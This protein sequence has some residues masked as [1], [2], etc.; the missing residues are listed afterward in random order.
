MDTD[1]QTEI[2]IYT[3]THVLYINYLYRVWTVCFKLLVI[4]QL[5]RRFR[6]IEHASVS[7]VHS[8][9]YTAEGAHTVCISNKQKARRLPRCVYIPR[10]SSIITTP[11]GAA[12]I[13]AI[14]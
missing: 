14:Y 8:Y 10:D 3:Y 6:S 13:Y 5:R 1:V 7:A 12:V 4:F 11:V 9:M 2:N